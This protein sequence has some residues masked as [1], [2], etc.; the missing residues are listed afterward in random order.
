MITLYVSTSKLFVFVNR[1]NIVYGPRM[2]RGAA[3]A[4]S[5]PSAINAITV[6]VG[7]NSTSAL[8]FVY[9]NEGS[10]RVYVRGKRCEVT[11]LRCTGRCIQRL[12]TGI[13]TD[14][15]SDHPHP[16]HAPLCPCHVEGGTLE[17]YF[18]LNWRSLVSGAP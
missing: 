5:L 16:S 13:R 1:V 15:R 2:A 7:S 4:T 11:P 14:H 9:G 10:Y 17:T 18:S 6:S 3:G 12:V 8:P